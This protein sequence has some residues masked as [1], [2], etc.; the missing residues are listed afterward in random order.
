M[1]KYDP[2]FTCTEV[3]S[4]AWWHR[5]E[6]LNLIRRPVRGQTII[7]ADDFFNDGWQIK[8]M[9]RSVTAETARRHGLHEQ[10]CDMIADARRR[11]H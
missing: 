1:R 7:L 6:S 2:A 3:V 8:W 11:M 4:Y 5:R 10:G 9:S